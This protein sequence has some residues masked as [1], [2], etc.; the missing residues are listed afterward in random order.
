MTRV[1]KTLVLKFV[2]IVKR[3][4]I[5]A[6]ERIQINRF[7]MENLNGKYSQRHIFCPFSVRHF[8]IAINRLTNPIWVTKFGQVLDVRCGFRKEGTE[9]TNSASIRNFQ[10]K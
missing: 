4:L 2:E 1:P 6:N 5:K 10:T 7:T 9:S 8:W 3:R